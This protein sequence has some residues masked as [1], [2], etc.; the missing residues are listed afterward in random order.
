MN[1]PP[2]SNRFDWNTTEH[3]MLVVLLAMVVFGSDMPEPV[4]FWPSTLGHAPSMGAVFL[5][6]A[7]ATALYQFGQ[8][9]RR[10]RAVESPA[11]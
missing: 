2:A 6:V 1:T 4:P 10:K 7:L 11:Q 3:Q 8:A 5:I 9:D